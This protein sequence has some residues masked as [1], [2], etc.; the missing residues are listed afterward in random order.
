MLSDVST[1]AEFP[2][3]ALDRRPLISIITVCL[4]ADAYLQETIDSVASQ[5][6]RDYE[7]LIIDGG[8]SDTTV[9]IIRRNEHQLATWVSEPDKGIADA[10]NKGV[11][12]SKGRY[13]YFLQADDY[14]AGNDVLARVST[15]VSRREA[16][17]YAFQVLFCSGDTMKLLQPVGFTMKTRFKHI[18][19]H[20]GLFVSKRVFELVGNFNPDYKILMD[21]D[22]VLRAQRA[23]CDIVTCKFPV[24]VMRDGGLSSR[25]SWP[26]MRERLLE[27]RRLHRRHNRTAPLWFLAYE[28]FSPLYFFYKWLRSN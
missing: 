27:E 4:N 17:I 2:Q 5:T 11:R 3:V 7:H 26:H 16:D 21:L 23:G 9:E 1:R 6:F 28:A 19:R 25:R 18:V 22:H 15:V 13:V 24:A 12:R 8:S 10:M 14:L 20:Q